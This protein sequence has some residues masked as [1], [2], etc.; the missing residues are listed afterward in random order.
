MIGSA[1][2]VG[3]ENARLMQHSFL[4]LDRRIKRFGLNSFVLT[5][6]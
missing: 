6:G 4:T 5:I 1:I 3:S 2:C